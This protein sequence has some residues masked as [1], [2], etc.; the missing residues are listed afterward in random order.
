MSEGVEKPN[1]LENSSFFA[2]V[3]DSVREGIL[4]CARPKRFTTRQ[5]IYVIDDPI[6]EIFFLVDGCAKVTQLTRSGEEVVLRIAAPGE[7]IG[8]LGAMP[9][10]VHSSTA[11]ALHDCDALVWSV[12]AFEAALLRYPALQRNVNNILGRRVS[13]M[14]GRIRR[15]ATELASNRVASELM[16]LSDQMGQRVNGHVEI[17]IPQEALAQMTAMDTFTVNRTLTGLENQG[18]L[19]IRRKCIEIHDTPGLSGLCM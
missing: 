12:E 19:R 8:E 5:L 17:Y 11:R 18:L 1:V 14:E 6:D 3:P 2:N 16:R 9:G 7:L 15:I 10:S 4:S 13:E